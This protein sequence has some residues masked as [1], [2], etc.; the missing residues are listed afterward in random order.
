MLMVRSRDFSVIVV[1]D[2]KPKKIN[3]KKR[4]CKIHSFL[5]QSKKYYQT[6]THKNIKVNK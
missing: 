1:T 4:H 2:T 6:Q 5:A 3:L